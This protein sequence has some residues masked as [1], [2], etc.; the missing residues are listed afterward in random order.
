MQN[1]ENTWLTVKQAAEIFPF[2]ESSLR[3]IIF[4]KK[5]NGCSKC[6]R[7]IGSRKLLINA[8]QFED[9]IDQQGVDN[10]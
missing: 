2:S 3:W 4:H 6:L 7:R 9:W 5:H 1:L 10:E 8:K